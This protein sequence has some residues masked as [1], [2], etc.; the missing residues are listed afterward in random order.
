M[1]LV[2]VSSQSD[3]LAGEQRPMLPLIAGSI[4]FHLIVLVGIPLSAKLVWRPKKFQRPQTFQLVRVPPAAVKTA[5][6]ISQE[7]AK[8]ETKPVPAKADSKPA[9]KKEEVRKEENL[10]ELESLLNALPSPATILAPGD[11]KY[12]HYL[13]GVVAKIERYWNPP[14]ENK[15]VSVTV[16]FTIFGSGLISDVRVVKSS[17]NVMLDN[18]GVRAVKLAAPFGKL[19]PGFTGN[20][21]ELRCELKPTRR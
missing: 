12:N 20:E 6:R 10:D 18:L 21:L 15:T 8:K 3:I 4:V 13:N 17:G 11:F 9:P 7:V 14:S 2:Q 5:Q 1:T 19:P 16:A